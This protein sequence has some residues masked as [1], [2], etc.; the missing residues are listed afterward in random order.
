MNAIKEIQ[1]NY[2][3]FVF[4]L[5]LLAAASFNLIT[6]GIVGISQAYTSILLKAVPMAIVIG[7]SGS[8]YFGNKHIRAARSAKKLEDQLIRFKK[9]NNIKNIYL[10]LPG[11]IACIA[12]LMTGEKQFLFISVAILI[13]M[14]IAFP[15]K[16]KTMAALN[17]TEKEMAKLQ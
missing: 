6:S 14:A 4:A 2:F 5:L 9:A 8:F 3:V 16:N 12:A 15:S 13:V 10:L 1:K 11:V 17:L 7:I